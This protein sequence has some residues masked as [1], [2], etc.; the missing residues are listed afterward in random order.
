MKK[1]LIITVS[2]F[3]VIGLIFSSSCRMVEEN[4]ESPIPE[5]VEE[6]EEMPTPEVG[7]KEK[8]TPTPEVGEKEE[9][10]ATEETPTT[11]P[12]PA[13]TVT[14]T[15]KPTL[16]GPV[17]IPE[18]SIPIIDAHSQVDE[19][20]ELEKIIQLMDEGGIACTILATRGNLTLEEL[21]SFAAK[22]PTRIT[23]ALRTKGYMQKKDVEYH[24]R[25]KKQV[26]MYQF[27]GM[28]EVLMY[29]AQKGDKAPEVIVQPDD[30]RVLAAIDVVVEKRWPFIV[31][32]EFAAAG[33]QH[34]EF[35]TKLEAL[36]LQ[37]PEHPFV[38]IH[39][40]QL[41]CTSVRQLIEAYPNIYFITSHSNPVVIEESTQPWINMFDGDK[42]STDWKQLLIKHPDRFILGFDNV[43]HKHWGQFYL[44]QVA[45]WRK[46]IT[47]LP[48]EVAHAFA[49]GNAER[50]W[51]LQ[52][53][54]K[55]E[56]ASHTLHPPLNSLVAWLDSKGTKYI[57]QEFL[58]TA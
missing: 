30:E 2:L 17:T 37:H 1:T 24:Q 9:T 6:K 40:G 56:K 32:I 10:S 57:I 21:I 51:N 13:P 20:V 43:F 50:L 45:L 14:P 52:L 39:M 44:D 12:T 46:A 58:E 48:V 28:A 49:H 31:H 18:G 36:L 11:T 19:Y 22:H 33:S 35:M 5:V 42:L 53:V 27:G 8:E 15:V 4:E 25:L 38:L 16:V 47:E 3:L 29:H 54:E 26:N 41:D 34:D 7:E 55:T 23:P